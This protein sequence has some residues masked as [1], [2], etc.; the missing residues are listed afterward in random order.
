MKIL[1]A[2]GSSRSKIVKLAALGL[3]FFS[4]MHTALADTGLSTNVQAQIQAF[5]AEKA[6]FTPTE[7]KMDSQLIFAYKQSKNLP[8]AG[9]AVPQLKLAVKPDASGNLK[10]EIRASST[11]DLV[12]QILKAGGT[13]TGNF[14]Q[15]GVVTATMPV[16]QLENVAASSSVV[17]MKPAAIAVHNNSDPE[18]VIAHRDD[19]GRSTFRLDGS[20]VKVGVMS[21]SVDF[22]SQAQSLGALGAV[23]VLPGQSGVPGTG[24]GTAMLEIVHAMAP[25]AQLF[26]STGD[27]G[28]AAFANNIRQ[29]RFTYGCDIIVDDLTY[30]DESPF[31]DGVVAQAVNAVTDSGGLYFSSAANSGN[32]DAGTSGTWEGDFVSGGAAGSPVN[33]KGGEVL[34]F[35][36]NNFDVVTQESSEDAPTALFWSD[37][38]GASTNDYDL[39]VLDSTGATIVSSSVTVQNGTQDPFEIVAAPLQNQ[40]IVVVLAS[41]TNR[42]LHIDTDRA[43]LSVGTQGSTRGH[44][45]ATNAFTVA[46]VDVGTAAG[47]FFIGGQ[48]N[49][50]EFFSSDG[51]RHM[52]YFANG[53]PIT[54]GDFSLTGGTVLP[55]PDIAAAN[56]VT[57]TLP[58]DSGLNP[59]FGTSAAA[60][61]A[62]GIAALIKSYNPSLN[63]AQIRSVMTTSALDIGALG[64]D[65]DSGS[66]IVMALQGLQG[67]P[68]PAPTPNLL[69]VTNIVSGGNGNGMIDNDE[70][71]SMDIVLTNVGTAAATDV[72]ATL[73]SS[74]PGVV[75]AISSASYPNISTNSSATNATSFHVSTSP[76]F[77]CGSTINFSLVLKSDQ[78]TVTNVFTVA[79]GTPG[80]PVR[81][82]S[83][84]PVAIPDD[85]PVGTNSTII[86]SNL[87]SGIAHV[88]VSLNII[89]PFVSDLTLQLIGPDGTSVV[90]AENAGGS[91]QDFGVD[92]S[93]PDR[94][95]FDDSA[96]VSINNAIAPF[97]G[98]F[99]PQQ[100]LASF[101]GK[102]GLAANGAWSLQMVDGALGDIGFLQCWSLN[103]T[104]ALC[105][106]GGGQC[107]GVDLSVGMSASPNPVT[108][109]SNLTYTISVTNNGPDTAKN[110]A[111][112]QSLPTNVV[113]VSAN[114]SQGTINVG[115]GAVS[116]NIGTLNV[117]D[118]ASVTVI[119]SPQSP[120]TIF[121]TATVGALEPDVNPFNNTVTV[122]TVVRLASSDL[123]VV[124]SQNPSPV[125]LDGILTYT[126]LVLNNG[127]TIAT[128]VIVSNTLPLNVAFVSVATSQGGAFNSAN[129]VIAGLGNLAV[130]SNATVTIQ[131]MPLVLGSITASSTV[132]SDLPDEVAANNTSII[133]DN[134]TAAADL[135]L[136]LNGPKVAVVGSN[137]VYTITALNAGPS[138][139]TGVSIKDTLPTGVALISAV[140][141]QGPCTN[142]G[143]VV[144]CQPT[145]IPVGSNVTITIT[146]STATTMLMN[147]TNMT[148]IDSASIVGA[149]GDPN[150]GNN[151]ASLSTILSIPT[152]NVI[153]AGFFLE[154]ESFRPANGMIDPGEQVTMQLRL[155]NLGNI[156][157][158]N[159]L[160]ATLLNSGGVVPV[161]TQSADYGMLTV[162]GP[163]TNEPFTFVASGTNGRTI[164]ASLQLMNG[165]A[166]LTVLKFTFT[167]P[168]TNGFA[169]ANNIIIPD[170]GPGSPF[171]S[172]NV[173]TGVTGLIGKV[174]VTMTNV[175]HTF[176]DDVDMLLVGPKG[177]NVLLM[178]HT[179][180]GGLL[181]NVSLTFDDGALNSLGQIN[182]LPT[183]SQILSGS[184]APTQNGDVNFTNNFKGTI[185]VNPNNPPP[186]APYG[187][188]LAVFNGTV[189]NG[190]WVLYV[191]D[192]ATGDAGEI[193]GGWALG[194]SSGSE[195][196]PVVDLGITGKASSNSVTAGDNLT[197]TFTITNNGPNPASVVQ[198]TNQLSTNV[199]L[200]S[201]T[202]SAHA[203][204][205]TDNGIVDCTFTNLSTGTNITVTVVVTAKASGTMTNTASVTGADSDPNQSNNSASVVTS[206]SAPI[207]DLAMG[208]T[209]P[210][211][212]VVGS[213]VTY[214]IT[215]TNNGPG[216]A[217]SA[218]LADMMQTGLRFVAGTSTLA[219]TFSTTTNGVTLCT[220]GNLVSNQTATVTVTLLATNSGT[221][222]NTFSVSTTSTDLNI[223]NNSVPL[224]TTFTLPAPDIVASGAHLI[225]GP[226]NGS[227]L[228]G[229]T[230]TISLQLANVG[231]ADATNLSATLLAGNGVMLSGGNNT[232]NYGVLVHGGP[233]IA[234][235][236]TFTVGGISN[237]ASVVATLQLSDDNNGTNL[238][239]VSFTFNLPQ[240]NSYANANGIVIPDHG[241]A[242]PYPSVITVTNGT[243]LVS[244]ATVTLNNFSHQFPN[245]VE[246][247]L[248][249]PA[250]QSVVL[251]SGVGGARAVTNITLTFDDAATNL[252]PSSTDQFSVNMRQLVSGTN[253]PTDFG[254]GM[255]F[256]SPAPA[257]PSASALT[258]F[259]GSNPAGTW[260]LYVLDDSPGDSGIIAG[261]WSLNLATVSPVNSAADLAVSIVKSSGAVA[262]GGTATFTVTITNKGP[263]AA[264]NV[265]I[266][267]TPSIGL[268]FTGTS[269]GV[270]TIN[271]NSSVLFN[272]GS[273]A[274]GSNTSFTISTSP[275][276]GGTLANAVAVSSDQTD[277]NPGDNTAQASFQVLLT[278]PTLTAT[279]GSTNG[280]FAL[281]LNISGPVGIYNIFATTN[282]TDAFST[283]T[284]V[285]SVTN[286]SSSVPFTDTNAANFPSRYYRAVLAQ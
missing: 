163:A 73:T 8:I 72:F 82:D 119:V 198:F 231:T 60:P 170:H 9:G 126:A 267:D 213:N 110:V 184:Y 1:K 242:T 142:V 30:A 76:A 152:L 268:T 71:N 218:N 226:A 245:D 18:G 59:F 160:T 174:T 225:G 33:G 23:T 272:I 189:A 25:G 70:C 150:I 64:V 65:R 210:T 31:Q 254:L 169:N 200:I 38:L 161:G 146:V 264:A 96:A 78:S 236:F 168:T 155:Q 284:T 274:A 220:L 36:T 118:T 244:K 234:E 55:K 201:A 281:T 115:S 77:I 88:S 171:P 7:Q 280:T 277:L 143:S 50:V 250:G 206:V 232:Q 190:N 34:S 159:H 147:V 95:T 239:P 134:V 123:S 4:G 180:S 262:T 136:T 177:Q 181:T 154:A 37:P 253:L 222:T 66:G 182:F 87:T 285:G 145:N 113:F 205:G 106:D 156:D 138:I 131:V 144:T 108:V 63:E 255:P 49:P 43:V 48:A 42:F 22:L 257:A 202:N 164:T 175:N 103:I 211:N 192:S 132:S 109:N 27:G 94:T 243:G 107:P 283:W 135:Q 265:T 127:P 252:L 111:V 35:G 217:V 237:S 266:T 279:A 187:T 10:V 5:E 90:L 165:S 91:G 216:I 172:T 112:N 199:T 20:G 124:L 100:Q 41:G 130:G 191:F 141:A 227:I 271:S 58:P 39:F 246:I 12:K 56:G 67:S 194:I 162:G 214:V 51:P 276:V 233:S 137:I 221:L 149:E 62:A 209:G 13:V 240:T 203:L 275:T 133:T 40:Q 179:G 29:L 6:S 273:L 248:V 114:S 140:S 84:A 44:N 105:V 14:P 11:P 68:V 173:V 269:L 195:V 17:F 129:K 52:F 223:T 32:F 148:L 235:P 101:T 208:V 278:P 247:M 24:E 121:S 256:A 224:A 183:N 116:C 251:M 89:H 215:I 238:P 261:G 83:L 178:S 3:T 228:A 128:N 46:A 28:E 153:A 286:S 102:A 2:S 15:L 85:N 125:L 139:S 120:G 204:T 75:V 92:C 61:H 207:A 53:K 229:Q 93:D 270:S 241:P 80:V 166:N 45:A 57:T 157:T 282:I 79:T 219:S 21:D 197:Y 99:Q 69:I 193:V 188:N 104:P 176:P 26:F 81:F 16:T 260:A 97:I 98:T 86:V 230:V 167:L 151:S 19:T 186:Q 74:T 258:N 158:S 212:S 54:P 47:S 263:S 122:S 185:T 196:N 117:G 249:G 259:V